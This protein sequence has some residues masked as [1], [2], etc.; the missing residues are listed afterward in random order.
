MEVVVDAGLPRSDVLYGTPV[1]VFDPG[2]HTSRVYPLTAGLPSDSVVRWS[3]DVN[4]TDRPTT[5]GLALP[6]VTETATE[7]F[8]LPAASRATAA[9]V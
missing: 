1:D 9:R 5:K 6:T 7:D 8:V 3:V 2:S 4:E